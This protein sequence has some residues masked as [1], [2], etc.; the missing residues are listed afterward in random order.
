MSLMLTVYAYMVFVCLYR[1]GASQSPCVVAFVD[2]LNTYGMILTLDSRLQ[3]RLQGESS[4]CLGL[5]LNLLP[6]SGSDADR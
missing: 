4:F 6:G 5:L 1:S 2:P 3:K